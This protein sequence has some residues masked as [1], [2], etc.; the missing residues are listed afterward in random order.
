MKLCYMTRFEVVM[1]HQTIRTSR[2]LLLAAPLLFASAT[3]SLETDKD[4]PV[5]WNADDAKMII[6]GDVRTWNLNNNVKVT[7]GTIE[8]TGNQAIFEYSVSTGELQ[9]VTV[10]GNPAHYQQQLDADENIVVGTSET[11]LFYTDES[12]G[13]TILDLVGN[14]NIESP[15]TTMKC[16]TISYLADRALIREANVCQGVLSNPTN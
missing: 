14:A 2:Y 7:Q 15:D 10:Y 5:Q 12:D 13:E 9:R 11:M 8:I 16:N 6:D 4:Q 1:N 3:F